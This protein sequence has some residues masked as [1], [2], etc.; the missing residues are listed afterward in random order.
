MHKELN[1]TYNDIHNA[2]VHL[3]ANIESMGFRPD[4]I[5][6][7]ARGGCIPGVMVS[8]FMSIPF[9]PIS[10]SA[11][12][13][14]GDNRNHSG[15]DSLPD[16]PGKNILIVDDICDTSLTLADIVDHYKKQGKYVQT[17]VLHYKVRAS[18]KHIPDYYWLK[19]PE[20]SGWVVYPYEK[21]EHL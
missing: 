5:V 9:T 6:G 16:I 13:G 14:A 15:L 19:I 7:V 1:P 8:H 11:K 18:G 2:C 4:R 20:N 10:Y 12:E 21:A 17:A 3:V